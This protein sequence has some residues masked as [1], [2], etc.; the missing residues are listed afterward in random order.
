MTSSNSA[1]KPK[2]YHA[3]SNLTADIANNTDLHDQKSSIGLFWICSSCHL[4]S[5]PRVRFAFCK[6]LKQLCN[7][8]SGTINM[9]KPVKKASAVA[10]AL[11][12][13]FTSSFLFMVV[14]GALVVSM[15]IVFHVFYHGIE[16]GFLLVSQHFTHFGMDG[17]MHALHLGMS[18]F[19]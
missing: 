8:F 12:Q 11:Q 10:N 19:F 1:Q 14:I 2:P 17:V 5:I 3:N 16:L 18:V 9:E 13:I 4:C 6:A 7:G 15:H